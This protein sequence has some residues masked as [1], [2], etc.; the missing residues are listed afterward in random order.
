M[1]T[2]EELNKRGTGIGREGQRL[3]IR[4]CFRCSSSSISNSHLFTAV[5]ERTSSGG[6]RERERDKGYRKRRRERMDTSQK[7]NCMIMR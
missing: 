7:T 4:R 5:T 2:W 6:G 1:G 3:T